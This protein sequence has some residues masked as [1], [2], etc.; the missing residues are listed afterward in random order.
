MTPDGTF[1]ASGAALPVRHDF[2]LRCAAVHPVHCDVRWRA[3]SLQS[4][5]RLARAHGA[6]AHGFTPRWYDAA[7]VEL[8]E[9]ATVHSPG[10]D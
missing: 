3:S 5:V 4:L 1:P 7:R 2:A 6:A 8:M 10:R 9:A